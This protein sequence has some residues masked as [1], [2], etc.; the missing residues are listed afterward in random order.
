M[1]PLPPVPEIKE[2]S[3]PFSLAILRASGVMK[4]RPCSLFPTEL[5]LAVAVFSASSGSASAASC[6]LSDWFAEAPPASIPRIDSPASPI[7]AITFLH[8]TVSPA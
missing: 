4:I 6:S 2:I 8:G 3:Y 5:E 1:R 7:H